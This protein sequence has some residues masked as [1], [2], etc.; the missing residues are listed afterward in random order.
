MSAVDCSQPVYGGCWCKVD[1]LRVYRAMVGA[2]LRSQL[3]Y[4]A[5]FVLWTIGQAVTIGSEL[6]ALWLLFQRFG[7][8]PGWTLPEVALLC[9]IVH[10]A[11]ALAET[12][13]RGFDQ[14]G[15][16]VRTGEFDRVLLRPA[17][18]ALLVAA[19]QF[20]LSRLGRL[21]TGLAALTWGASA[22]GIAF[23]PLEC[24][25][26]LATVVSGVCVFLG[27]FVL[28]AT[29]CFWTV[30]SLEVVNALTY[31]GVAAAEMPLTIYPNP[32]RWLF[33]W[34]VPVACMNHIPADRLLARSDS[35]WDWLAPLAGF[36]F[37][38]ASLQVWNWGVRR[39]LSTGS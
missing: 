10:I 7:P 4:R 32:V 28:Q 17:P 19:Q 5:S 18:S 20:E 6:A 15:Q 27:V 1:S 2:S 29:A 16:T 11:F 3:A 25:Y 14:F 38:A 12:I 13:G 36:A 9:G 34:V 21:G 37:L 33:T 8:L 24:C 39:Y 23:G 30:E 35:N 22:S 26:L 31:G